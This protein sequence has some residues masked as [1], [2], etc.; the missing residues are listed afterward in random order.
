M[1]DQ[2]NDPE[3][4]DLRVLATLIG[5]DPEKIGFYI[6]RFRES[7]RNTLSEME[8]ALIKNDFA[9][10]SRLGHR[11]KS[12]AFTMGAMRF[13]HICEALEQEDLEGGLVSARSA[14]DEL[15]SLMGQIE[16]VLAS[17]GFAS[18]Q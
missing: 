13:G 7:A 14:V 2:S 6:D 12:V 16:Q 17:C 11:I 9:A 8:Q 4:I 10:L 5:N 18:N 1:F 15:K 3:I